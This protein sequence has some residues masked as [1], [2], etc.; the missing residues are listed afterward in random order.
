[1]KARK[2]KLHESPTNKQNLDKTPKKT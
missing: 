1:L 2:E